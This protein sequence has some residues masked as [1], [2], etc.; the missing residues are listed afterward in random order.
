MLNIER[1]IVKSN[2]NPNENTLPNRISKFESD[3]KTTQSKISSPPLEKVK[4]SAPETGNPYVK[5]REQVLAKMPKG[6][7]EIIASMEARKSTDNPFYTQFVAAIV[8]AAGDVPSHELRRASE[9]CGCAHCR[10]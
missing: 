8:R 4:S 9:K 5:A 7:A 10:K 6:D 1:H 3:Q 2:T